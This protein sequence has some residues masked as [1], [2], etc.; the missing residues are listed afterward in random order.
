MSELEK[1]FENEK[2]VVHHKRDNFAEKNVYFSKKEK[3]RF[4]SDLHNCRAQN[5]ASADYYV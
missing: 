3:K 1:R 4:L 5:S 2:V